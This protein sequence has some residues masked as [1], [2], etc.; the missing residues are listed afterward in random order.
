M[1]VSSSDRYLTSGCSREFKRYVGAAPAEEARLSRRRDAE[2]GSIEPEAEMSKTCG[3]AMVS[4]RR[5]ECLQKRK[6][7]FAR[8]DLNVLACDS[9]CEAA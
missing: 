2:C 5:I 1:L 8:L 9:N 6:M 7:V 4:N 3:S